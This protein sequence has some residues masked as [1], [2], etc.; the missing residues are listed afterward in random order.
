[1]RGCL[2]G[3]VDEQGLSHWCGSSFFEIIFILLKAGMRAGSELCSIR[4]SL[5]VRVAW[6]AVANNE[7]ILN[8]L[9]IRKKA[10]G[11]KSSKR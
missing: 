2:P 7:I 5:T 1:M 11:H 8:L 3:S 4:R 10:I 6:R 9:K